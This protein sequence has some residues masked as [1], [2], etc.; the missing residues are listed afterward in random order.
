M[1]LTASPRPAGRLDSGAGPAGRDSEPY[2]AVEGCTA[3]GLSESPISDARPR[4]RPGLF[5]VRTSTT[6]GRRLRGARHGAGLRAGAR[7]GLSRDS[8]ASR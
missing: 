4:H 5:L 7:A 6:G 1:H 3:A 2:P 8:A